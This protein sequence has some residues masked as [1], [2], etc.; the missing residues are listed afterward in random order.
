MGSGK[1]Y[2]GQSH[3]FRTL[4]KSKGNGIGSEAHIYIRGIAR[5]YLLLRYSVPF[6]KTR[7]NNG[8]DAEILGEVPA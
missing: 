7:I 4:G 1:N 6:R 5:F 2:K 3:D 8:A